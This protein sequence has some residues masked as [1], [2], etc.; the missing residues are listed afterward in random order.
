MVFFR[1]L[2]PDRNLHR[3][4]KFASPF[5]KVNCDIFMTVFSVPATRRKIP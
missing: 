5:Y 4:I 1:K 2:T 3:D